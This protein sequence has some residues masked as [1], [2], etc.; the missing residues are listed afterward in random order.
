[1]KEPEEDRREPRT[2]VEELLSNMFSDWLMMIEDGSVLYGCPLILYFWSTNITFS[3]SDESLEARSG[4]ENWTGKIFV[5][6][7][8]RAHV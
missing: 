3:D 8:G 6:E 4:D 2:G 5:E 1:M 7:I